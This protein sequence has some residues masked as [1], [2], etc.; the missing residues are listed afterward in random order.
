MKFQ[1]G[2]ICSTILP[3]NLFKGLSL[4]RTVKLGGIKWI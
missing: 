3:L 1:R 4:L 2:N